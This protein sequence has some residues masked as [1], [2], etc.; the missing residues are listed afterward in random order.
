MRIIFIVHNLVFCIAY[1]NVQILTH[2]FLFTP[3]HWPQQNLLSQQFAHETFSV[4]NQTA[5][6]RLNQDPVK[7]SPTHSLL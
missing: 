7:Q 4:K 5:R 2:Y 6:C 3:L 1:Q